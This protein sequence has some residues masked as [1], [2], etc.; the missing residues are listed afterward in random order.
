MRALSV[1]GLRVEF[2]NGNRVVRPIDQL[3]FS[4]D[5]GEIAVVLG[6]SG[7][8]KTTLLSTIGG[9]LS[10]A[11]GRIVVD[12]TE[13]T[14]LNNSER[15]TYRR[16][17]VGFV[18]QAFNL[19]ESL[20]ARE[21]IAVPLLLAGVPRGEALDRAQPLVRR[22]GLDGHADRPPHQLS[23]GQQQRV[24]IARGL[25]ND[26][27][28]L[29]ADEPTANLDQAQTDRIIDLL[30][31][32]RADGMVMLVS[33][34]DP[35]MVPIADEILQIDEEVLHHTAPPQRVEYEAGEVI[36]EQGE[37]GELVY[38]IESGTVELV[39]GDGHGDLVTIGHLGPGQHFG[40]IGPILGIPRSATAKA[41]AASVLLAYRVAE[42]RRL[43]S[44]SAPAAAGR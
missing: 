22:V 43:K 27:V 40:E 19:I 42:F 33:S 8:G 25:V 5:W 9:L 2:R 16:S 20:S 26:P 12:G 23:G 7:S 4:I 10:P 30:A 17:T 15:E 41:T 28:V 18:F 44:M 14:G 31:E 3:T 32:L 38:V 24:A 35:R 34:H 29:L 21:N 11:A 39:A 13:V 36:F 37:W 1:E 6:P